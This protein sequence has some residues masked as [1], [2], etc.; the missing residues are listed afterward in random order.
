MSTGAVAFITGLPSS[1]KSTFAERVA[2]ILRQRSAAVCVLD[3]DAG[4]ASLVPTPDYTPEGRMSFYRTLAHLSALLARQGQLVL[5]PATANR[6][7]YRELARE[8][9]PSFVEVWVDTSREECER[10]DAK[11]LYAASRS[12][13]ASF[14]PGAGVEYEAPL[15]PHV[16]AHGGDDERAARELARMLLERLGA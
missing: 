11:G 5:V 6:R 8:L 2:A 15:A 3:G 13:R 16:V 7:A 9:A 4:R 1:G 12:G 10:R 14:V